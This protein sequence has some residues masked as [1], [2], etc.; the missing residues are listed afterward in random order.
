MFKR[1][2]TRIRPRSEGWLRE[3]ST[4][5]LLAVPSLVL[6]PRT[7]AATV[8]GAFSRCQ[9]LFTHDLSLA[10]DTCLVSLCRR[11]NEPH[12]TMESKQLGVTYAQSACRPP[13]SPR[14]QGLNPAMTSYSVC[15]FVLRVG[16]R[17]D[18]LAGNP[19]SSSFLIQQV[20]L[21]SYENQVTGI[22][23]LPR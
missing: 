12:E 8:P 10:S 17:L 16:L 5:W 3:R 11:Y 4:P 23:S 2:T 21:V 9:R 19:D 1:A 20:Q 15:S 13:I 22:S 14:M 7:C 6:P 18:T